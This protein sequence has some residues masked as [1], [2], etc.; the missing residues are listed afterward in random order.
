MGKSTVGFG[1]FKELS[2]DGRTAAYLDLQQL[3]FLADPPDD[4]PGGHEVVAGCVADLWAQ[5]RAVGAQDLVPAGRVE[6]A[7]DV[8]RY[9]DALGATLLG[10]NAEDAEMVLHD[11]LNHQGRM[12]GVE[13]ADITLDTAD[14]SVEAVTRSA[15]AAFDSLSG[16]APAAPTA[17]ST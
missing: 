3:S 2:E 5:E 4:A 17:D 16:A 11:A 6:Q 14:K 8:Q 12:Q 1:L 9:R 15:G 10:L 13:A 7:A